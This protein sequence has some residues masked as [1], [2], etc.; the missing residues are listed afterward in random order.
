MGVRSQTY[1][2]VKDSFILTVPE[3]AFRDIKSVKREG[4]GF[5]IVRTGTPANRQVL[6]TASGGLFTFENAFTGVVIDHGTW[7]EIVGEKVFIIW[8]E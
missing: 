1:N 4:L 2:T 7:D 8:N 5:D 6:Y 3:L